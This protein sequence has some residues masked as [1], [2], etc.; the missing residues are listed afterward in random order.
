MAIRKQPVALPLTQGIN[1]KIDEKQAPLGTMEVLENIV[2]D[3]PGAYKKRTGYDKIDPRT[4]DSSLIDQPERITIFKNELVVFNPTTTYSYSNSMDLWTNKGTVSNIYPKSQP[5]IRNS[6]QQSSISSY[7]IA[8]LDAYAWYDTQDTGVRA[9]IVDSNTGNQL[10]SNISLNSS[11]IKPII[12]PLNGIFYFLYIVGSDLKAKYVRANN[13]SSISS[14]I[15]VISADIHASDKIFDA[16]YINNRICI[17]YKSSTGTLK[18][19]YILTDGSLSA[20][21]EFA[22]ETPS[23]CIN[24][25][26]DMSTRLCITYYDGSDVVFTIKNFN[27]STSLLAPTAIETISDITN[28]CSITTDDSTYTIYYEQSAAATYNHLVRKNTITYSGSVGT[29]ADFIRSCGLASKPFIKSEI[30]YLALIHE[31]N[32]QSTIYICNSNA[33]IVCK[34]QQGLCG[35]LLNSGHLPEISYI[36]DTQYLYSH[37]IKGRTVSENNTL[38]SLLGVN[39]V[40]LDFNNA[41]K[42]SNARLGDNL[43][44]AGGMIQNYDGNVIVEHGFHLYPENISNTTSSSTGGSMSDGSYQY[45]AVYSWIDNKGYQHRSAPATPIDVVLSGGTST[46]TTTIRIPTLRITE[47][48]GVTVELYRTEGTGTIFY[49]VTSPTNPT[50]NNASVDYIDLIDTT[51][52]TAL[53]SNEVLY[54][55]SGELENIAPPA[56]SIIVSFQNRIWLSGLENEYQ[57]QYSKIRS[58]G[59]PV[60][61]NDTLTINI[62]PVGGPITALGTMDDKIIVFKSSS[63]FFLSGNG[64]DNSGA[65]NDFIDPEFISADVGCVSQN[66]I[67]YTPMGLMFQSL[68]GIYLIDRGLNISYIGA[69]VEHFNNLTVNA[70]TLVPTKNQVIFFTEGD[71]LVF[72]YFTQQWATFTN[73]Q[74][75]S[76]T[77][78]NNTLYYIRYN[79]DIFKQSSSFTD[80]GSF[81]RMRIESSWMNFGGIQGYQRVYRALILG[82]YR[83]PHKLV[84]EAAYNY[85][86][87]YLDSKVVD[88]ADFTEDS[89]YGS[90][91]PYGTNTYGGTGNKY[92]L[93]LDFVQ[94]KCESIKIRITESQDSNYG[95][96]LELSNI[97]LVVGSK[98]TEFKP[99]QSRIYGNSRGE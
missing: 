76:A 2:F 12:Q 25:T 68:K 87:P 71:A 35:Q 4:I 16:V 66:S 85:N 51:A 14:E 82:K 83:S 26:T 31:S 94:Q 70:A 37:Q 57:L 29:A 52:D 98:G 60:T 50:Y 74:G 58:D 34:I 40:T 32:L 19:K 89:T 75:I 73:H 39:T 55:T 95:E 86:S 42:Y 91:S 5:V 21:Q 17:C 92:Q 77:V 93:R 3:E 69:P 8:N 45:T 90:D 59:Q 48:S 67:V 53:I 78:L 7:H 22:S 46:Q 28:V 27:L 13:P 1:T 65:S 61:F 96:G 56:A 18:F 11:G 62:D 99:E 10:F 79:N 23:T 84:I 41:V 49:Q 20:A 30:A 43:H 72:N 6:Y 36:S 9:T 81:I 24:I 54:T 38:F 80:N 97:A 15:T 64:P 33:E 47:K 63:V 88:T 44:V